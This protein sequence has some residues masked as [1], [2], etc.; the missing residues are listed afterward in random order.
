MH[1]N[2]CISCRP[3]A[4][5]LLTERRESR[6]THNIRIGRVRCTAILFLAFAAA[7]T[8]NAQ[9][10]QPMPP[11]YKSGFPL[12]LPNQ[13]GSA[14]QPGNTIFSQVV[15]ADLGLTPGFKSLVFGL[16]NGR[17][18]VIRRNPANGAWETAPG[19]P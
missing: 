4:G 7:G 13:P 9:I 15:A 3:G 6:M 10:V 12:I 18:Y 16:R 8:A 1:S 2:E 17:L 5:H 19:W 11:P 14:N